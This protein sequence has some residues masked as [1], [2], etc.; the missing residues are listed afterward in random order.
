M[1]NAFISTLSVVELNNIREILRRGSLSAYSIT[2]NPAAASGNSSGTFEGTP[3]VNNESQAKKILNDRRSG[4]LTRGIRNLELL[5][6]LALGTELTSLYLFDVSNF[7]PFSGNSKIEKRDTVILNLGMTTIVEQLNAVGIGQ[8]AIASF[9]VFLDG[10]V[11]LLD[12][13]KF[14][15][16]DR[17]EDIRFHCRNLASILERGT[18]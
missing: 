11:T 18:L 14:V 9:N 6:A 17:E 7:V 1:N 16:A 3:T 2:S 10:V 5:N 4:V 15:R 13:G 12:A 8:D